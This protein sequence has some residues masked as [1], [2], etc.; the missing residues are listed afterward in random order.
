MENPSQAAWFPALE[1]NQGT[2]TLLALAF[3][4]GWGLWEQHRA[5]VVEQRRERRAIT[6][7]SDIIERTRNLLE[8]CLLASCASACG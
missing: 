6:D 4:I 3:A 7:A 2:L 1:A 8:R 5:N